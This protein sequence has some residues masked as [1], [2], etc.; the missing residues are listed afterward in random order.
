M[1]WS[2]YPLQHVSEGGLGELLGNKCIAWQSGHSGGSGLPGELQDMAARSLKGGF[3]AQVTSCTSKT[4][5][6]SQ[7]LLLSSLLLSYQPLW[8]IS[9]KQ[10]AGATECITI[11]VSYVGQHFLS[12]VFAALFLTQPWVMQGFTAY[13][14]CSGR[15]S[16]CIQ[17]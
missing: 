14:G 16:I 2:S 5:G 15:H 7:P 17:V 13:R 9:L 8:P 10:N 1:D 4:P 3:A 12:R 6:F 11:S